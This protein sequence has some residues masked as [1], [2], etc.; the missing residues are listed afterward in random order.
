MKIFTKN[1]FRLSESDQATVVNA[2]IQE[3]ESTIGRH[4]DPADDQRVEKQIERIRKRAVEH[5][6][7]NE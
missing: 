1:F 6:V 3:L 7:F 2:A 4:V 5:G